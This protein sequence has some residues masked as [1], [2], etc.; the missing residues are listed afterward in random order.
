MANEIECGDEAAKEKPA[1]PIAPG[2]RLFHSLLGPLTGK[3]A[4]SWFL[5][6]LLVL[7][8]RWFLFENYT[9]PTGSMEPTLHGDMRWL[10][11][12]H[13]A[14]NKF[15]YGARIPF[16]NKRLY[17]LWRPE[18]WDIVVFKT[19]DPNSE[20]GTLVKRIVG[21]PGERINIRD[22]KIWVNGQPAEPPADLKGVLNYTNYLGTS[23]AN[24]SM[25]A[26]KMAAAKWRDPDLNPFNKGVQDLYAELEA[27]RGKMNGADPDKMDEETALGYFNTLTPVTQ[28]IFTELYSRK[29]AA[30]YPLRYGILPDD[31]Y[32]VV[33]PD[34]YLVCGDN[35]LDSADGR[36]FGWLPDGHILGRVSCTWW[37]L[38]RWRDFTGFSRTWWGMLLLYGTP[39]LVAAFEMRSHMRRRAAR[40]STL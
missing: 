14:V 8:I 37:P 30:K 29:I 32:A 26:V 11:G 25:F 20:H 34:C 15:V 4:L 40:R 10:R 28:K 39:G 16:T 21:L 38:N 12:D 9:I 7:L 22:G 3:N 36:Y 33:P 35:S 18:R 24:V 31:E 19:I 1:D 6:I 27:L 13:V 2:K 17:H 5:V 23:P